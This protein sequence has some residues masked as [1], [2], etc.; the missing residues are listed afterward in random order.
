M[1][2]DNKGSGVQKVLVTED[3]NGARIDRWFKRHFPQITFGK[4]QKMM[5]KGDVRLNG[6]RVKGKE[7]VEVGMEV[8]VP[9]IN[10]ELKEKPREDTY[11]MTKAEIAEVQSWVI[12]MDKHVIVINKPAGLATQG[13]TGIT[14]HLDGMLDAL[15]YEKENKPKL[16]HRLDKD[17]SGA[18]LLARSANAAGILAK[19]FQ[20][21]ETDKRYWAVVIGTPNPKEGRIALK[22][23]R[24]SNKSGE[25]MVVTDDGKKSL[26]D[27][28]VVDAALHTASWLT[29]KPHTGRKHQLRLHCAEIGHPIVGD[30]KYGGPESYLSGNISRKMHLH[31]HFI[32]FPHPDGGRM[33]VVAPLNEHM[34]ATFDTLGF[35]PREYVDPFQED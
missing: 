13:G 14:K 34:A 25:R 18:M 29:L 35:D 11:H 1:S 3:D 21:R 5:R 15:T 7:I 32:D 9:P 27:Y 31:S 33:K 8:R 24:V 4:L 30:S 6:K 17:T 28:E 20:S 12:H 10:G 23:D 2:E 19:S 26:T 22:M 16:V